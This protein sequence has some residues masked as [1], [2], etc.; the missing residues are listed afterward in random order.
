MRET[1]ASTGT[2]GWHTASMCTSPP[3]RCSIEI[4]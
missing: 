1:A 2:D 3:S 4:K